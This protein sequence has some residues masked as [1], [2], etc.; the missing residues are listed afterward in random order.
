MARL[1]EDLEAFLH[2]PQQGERITVAALEE[3]AGERGFGVL[4]A[5]LS[6]PSA[7]PLPAPGYSIPFAV[8]ILFL[9]IQ[10]VA[11]SLVPWLPERIKRRS[12]QS[13][14]AASILTK[15]SRLLRRIELIS[16]P[17]HSWIC[18]SGVG[19]RILGMAITLMAISMLIPVPGTNTL[20]ALS[21]FLMGFGLLDDD[22]ILSVLGMG[23]SVLA[24]IVTTLIL[25]VGFN[26]LSYGAHWLL[27]TG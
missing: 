22:G 24:A 18:R 17:R 20:P 5:L 11:G 14:F 15:G 16:R 8:L 13:G 10:L 9:S 27:S 1:S 21:I 12:V 23:L 19:R 3:M 26:I 4:L 2:H 25:T 7:L 6:L